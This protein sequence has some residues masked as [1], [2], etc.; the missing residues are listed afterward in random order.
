MVNPVPGYGITTAYRKAGR[1]W[2]LGF[3]TGADIAGGVAGARINSATP[4]TV[5]AA[6]AYD[7]SYGY[8]VIIRWGSYDVWYCHMP[9]GKA[10]VR[11]GQTVTAG[12]QIGV[13]GSTGNV[14]GPHLHMELRVKGGNFAAANFR[15][16]AIAINY[17]SV[18]APAPDAGTALPVPVRYEITASALNGRSGPGT[19]YAIGAT[20]DKG[21][22]FT[23]T[24]QSG[25]WVRASALWYHTDYLKRVDATPVPAPSV[26]PWLRHEHLNTWGDDG[27]EGTRTI[28][29]RRPKMLADLVKRKAEIITLNEVRDNQ[30]AAW[31]KGLAAEGYDVPLAEYGN[32]VAVPKGT[33]I[34][35]AGSYVLPKS[36]QGEGRDEVLARV[37]A[38]INGHWVHIGVSHFDYR[39]GARFDEIRVKQGKSVIAAMERFA[40]RY[41]LPTWKTR[42]VIGVDENS[43]SW[44]RDKA[45]GPAGIKAA[46]KHVIDAIYGNRPTL[47][48][49]TTTTASDHPIVWAVFGKKA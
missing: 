20:R 27:G 28:D 38:L 2:S 13:T 43:N 10:T 44:V 30:R 40:A 45:F 11:V 4:G 25:K 9:A 16:P 29:A 35:Y 41:R 39:P 36:V 31:K 22:R 8:K 15:D 3:H 5:I 33:Q 1:L 47:S 34:E 32:L 42:T 23:A 12:Q 14:T 48:T 24:R 18:K 46:V 6:N 49:G 21:I 7:A 26:V 37:R 19:D 17:Q